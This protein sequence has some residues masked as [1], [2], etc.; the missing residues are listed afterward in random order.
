VNHTSDEHSWFVESRS[1]KDNRYRD[2]YIWRP[3]VDEKTPNNWSSFFSGPA[4]QLDEHTNEYYLHLFSTKQPDLNWENPE[5]RKEIYDMMRWWLDK[6][7]DGFRMDVIN[8]ISKVPSLPDAPNTAPDELGW[9]GQYFINGPRVHDYLQE[10][11]REVLSQ[12]DVMTV[13]ETLSVTPEDVLQ[14]VGFDSGELNMVFQFELMDIDSG[15]GGKWDVQPWSLVEFKRI[16]T[17]WQI[18]LYNRGWNSLYLNNHDQ[19]RLVSRFGNDRDYH[20][21]SAKMLATLL[22]T[23]QG[24]PFIYQGEEIGMTNVQFGSIDEYRDIETLNW[25]AGELS[26]ERQ[27]SEL[28]QSIYAKGRDNARTPMQWTDESAAGFSSGEPWLQVNSNYPEI[29]VQRQT[30]DPNSIVNYYR[31]LIELRKKHL[32][33]VYGDY[34]LLNPSDVAIY[35]FQRRLGQDQLITVLNFTPEPQIFKWEAEIPMIEF[36][37]LLCNYPGNHRDDADI[38]TLRPY[39][40]RVYLAQRTGQRRISTNEQKHAKRNIHG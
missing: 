22:H 34:K 32:V 16:F 20:V 5:V 9:G 13:G 8:C 12:Y 11:N 24:T 30:D 39:E 38:L 2:Y 18:G 35:A 31:Q 23:L 21:E 3:N 25:Y 17:R 28:M 1:D 26:K 19:P 7:V 29:N 10:M 33:T 6:G 36:E 37:L 14:Y 40:A 15:P 27:P 4:W